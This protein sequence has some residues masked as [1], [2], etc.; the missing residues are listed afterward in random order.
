MCISIL[1]TQELETGDQS[2]RSSDLHI[3]F[4]SSLG[5][6]QSCLKTVTTQTGGFVIKLKAL[7]TK[8]FAL[9]DVLHWVL[10]GGFWNLK[11]LPPLTLGAFVNL[12]PS[13]DLSPTRGW[14]TASEVC[15]EVQAT[16]ME[17]TCWAPVRAD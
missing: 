2:S 8:R 4:E 12:L 11:S 5:Y 15:R 6:M 7:V 9:L 10:L 17:K 13:L 3:E 14:T 16:A 1:S